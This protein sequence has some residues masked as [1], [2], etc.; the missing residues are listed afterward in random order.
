MTSHVSKAELIDHL[1]ERHNGRGVF[2][3]L[4]ARGGYDGPLT[5]LVGYHATIHRLAGLIG[6]LTHDHDGDG[7][8]T[9]LNVRPMIHHVGES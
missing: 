7:R 6:G 1:V 5:E 3:D 2:S 8:Q 4:Q 9:G